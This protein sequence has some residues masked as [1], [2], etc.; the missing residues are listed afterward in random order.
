MCKGYLT[1]RCMLGQQGTFGVNQGFNAV[2][3]FCC[4]DDLNAILVVLEGGVLATRLV[5]PM[6]GHT[7][8]GTVGSTVGLAMNGSEVVLLPTRGLTR[9]MT[10]VFRSVVLG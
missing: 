9:V 7:V 6:G 2:G 10:S 1:I 5:K 4:G 3:H 8:G